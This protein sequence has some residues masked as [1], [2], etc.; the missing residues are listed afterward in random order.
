M[1]IELHVLGKKAQCSKSQIFL[2]NIAPKN[3]DLPWDKMFLESG[4]F[5]YGASLL[6]EIHSSILEIIPII[7]TIPPIGS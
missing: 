2:I 1:I 4:L 3:L 7:N 6:S 5:I